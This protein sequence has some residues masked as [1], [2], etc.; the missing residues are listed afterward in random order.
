MST[1]RILSALV[2]SLAL[3]CQLLAP[4]D[5]EHV[6][7]KVTESHA[8]DEFTLTFIHVQNDSRCPA[9]MMCVWAGNVQIAVTAVDHNMHPAI[10]AALQFLNTNSEPR[11]LKVG[12]T[13]LMLDSITPQRITADSIPQ[14]NY[15]AWFTVTRP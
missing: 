11:S 8:F 14:A 1:R 12:G 5:P 3:G 2:L 15:S 4:K 10:L 6:A 13:T 9:Q 7:L